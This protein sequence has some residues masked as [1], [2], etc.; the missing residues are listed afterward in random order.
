MLC[1]NLAVFMNCRGQTSATDLCNKKEKA[2]STVVRFFFLQNIFCY[3]ILDALYL[4]GFEL[5]RS[6][7]AK[8]RHEDL[9]LAALLVDL[10]YLALEVL[11]GPVND[12]NRV[13]E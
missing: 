2:G 9:D 7:A 11:E 6:L 4:V 13:V 5:D 1:L 3:T 10:S 8:H 12:Y